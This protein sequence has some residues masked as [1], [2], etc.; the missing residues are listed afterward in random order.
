[1]GEE[2]EGCKKRALVAIFRFWLFLSFISRMIEGLSTVP[3]AN[4]DEIQKDRL[5]RAE[6]IESI[7]TML[8]V[9]YSFF[10]LFTRFKL[11]VFVVPGNLYTNG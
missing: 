7:H 8:W 5:S 2:G 3:P 10:F 1:M 11:S 4:H 6:E 9:V